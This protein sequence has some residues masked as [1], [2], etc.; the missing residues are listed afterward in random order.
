MRIALLAAVAAA[1]AIVLENQKQGTPESEWLIDAGDPSIEGFSAQFTLNHGQTVDFKIDTDS[2]NYR[3]DIYRLGYYGGDGARLVHT[4]NRNLATAQAQPLP[5]FDPVR[6]LVDAGNWSV[7]AS[8]A[9]A[10]PPPS[11]RS[12]R[13]Q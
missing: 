12:S 6:K 11:R 7:S 9:E 4:I 8:W 5:M 3:I 10:K 13:R 1:N 2:R